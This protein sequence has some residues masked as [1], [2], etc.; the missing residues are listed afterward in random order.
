MAD[1][2]VLRKLP[3]AFLVWLICFSV[4]AE[5]SRSHSAMWPQ[6]HRKYAGRPLSSSYCQAGLIAFCPTGMQPNFMPKFNATDTLYVYALKAPVWE[7]KFGALLKYFHIMHDAV[8]FYH[9]QSGVN[10]T[11]EWYELFQLFNCTFPHE[12]KNNDLLWC[13]QGAAC[14]YKG[15]DDKHWT[16][17]G[18]LVKVAEITGQMFNHFADWVET[19][20]NTYPYYETWTVIEKPG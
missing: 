16:E 9:V 10:M 12:P 4:W 5:T 13:N 17:N 2:G 1:R 19:D 14:I 18:T 8:G 15:I 3:L 11:M 6:P 20:N 7:F